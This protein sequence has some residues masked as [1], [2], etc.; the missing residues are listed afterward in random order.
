MPRRGPLLELSREHHAAL[1]LARD[2][3]AATDAAADALHARILAHHRD[4]LADHFA[5]EERLLADHAGAI[6]AEVRARM[7]DD[8]AWL[9][10]WID[11]GRRNI[12]AIR[13][14]GERIGQHVR[15]EERVAW[16]LLQPLVDAAPDPG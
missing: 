6:A 12:A 10:A 5:R 1:V 7:L 16:P 4:I 14:Y 3:K 2:C 15:Y 13:E 8:H 9:R 11:A